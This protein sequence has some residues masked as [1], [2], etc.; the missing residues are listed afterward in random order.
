MPDWLRWLSRIN[1][2]SYEVDSLRLLLVGIPSSHPWLDV[3]V[4]VVA[5]IVGIASASLL[6]RRLV[7]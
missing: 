3:G 6:L 5:A 1:P 2:L 7:R 4:L